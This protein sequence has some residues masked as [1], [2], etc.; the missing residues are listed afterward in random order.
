VATL[1]ASLSSPASYTRS[2][3][4]LLSE[5][6]PQARVIGVLGKPDQPVSIFRG[7]ILQTCRKWHAQREF[8]STS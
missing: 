2:Q 1:P 5:L 4:E 6:L 8:S 3:L 7:E